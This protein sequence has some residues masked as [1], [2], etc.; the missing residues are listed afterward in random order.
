MS[1]THESARLTADV[2][3]FARHREAWH[4]LML[5][6]RY[7]PF[8]RRLAFPGGH[9]DAGETFL[10]AA[11]RELNEE[12]GLIA[13]GLHQ[14]GIY[15]RPDRDP[16]G[17]YVTVAF[18][19]VMRAPDTPTAGDDARRAKW[20]PLTWLQRN[21]GRLAF[22]HAAILADAVDTLADVTGGVPLL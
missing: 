16:R 13:G 6:R 10:Y 1:D 8:A 15:D 22:D 3:A 17:R 12:T 7:D 9:V 11:R 4:V 19:A 21:T 2:I 14:V 18:L 5:E 20:F